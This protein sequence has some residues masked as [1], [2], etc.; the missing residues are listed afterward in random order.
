MADLEVHPSRSPVAW[1]RHAHRH[2]PNTP[3]TESVFSATVYG[4]TYS[5]V[6]MDRN[7]NVA[8]V[9]TVFVPILMFVFLTQV[10]SEDLCCL[11]DFDY[12][13]SDSAAGDVF[14]LGVF[15]GNHTKD[16]S[17]AGSFYM[18][19]CTVMKCDP[20]GV[21]ATCEQDQLWDYHFLVGS[22]TVFS[23]LQL[24]GTFSE[25][26]RVFPEVLFDQAVLM[27]NQ[28]RPFFCLAFSVDIGIY[29]FNR[30]NLVFFV[31]NSTNNLYQ[32]NV[33]IYNLSKLQWLWYEPG[34]V[35]KRWDRATV[36]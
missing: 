4:D 6:P 31:F 30:S 18:E 15:S 11:A 34:R 14:S 25:D 21:A 23:R 19:M 7:T 32:H 2:A 17:V 35:S 13:D 27:P 5:F 24:S 9:P 8:K 10:C 1:G 12:L 20:A 3:H 33:K 16:G 26:T 22:D 36:L 29:L 28:V